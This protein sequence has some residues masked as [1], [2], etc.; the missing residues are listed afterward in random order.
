M[1]PNPY[2]A[3][4]ESDALKPQ[5]PAR[6]KLKATAYLLIFAAVIGAI[7][8]PSW[9]VVQTQRIYLWSGPSPLTLLIA[10]GV[11]AFYAIDALSGSHVLA[12]S[13]FAY[14]MA[15]VYGGA[16]L[17]LDTSCWLFARRCK[18]P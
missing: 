10:P 13:A 12:A 5:S 8:G 1:G 6:F 7:E 2:Q 14:G 17:V 11:Y 9:Y 15:Y 16:G 3:P 4:L 18:A